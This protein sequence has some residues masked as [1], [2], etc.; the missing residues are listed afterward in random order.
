VA[1]IYSPDQKAKAFDKDANGTIFGEGGGIVILKTL[2][3]ALADGDNIHA[4]IKGSAVNSDGRRSNGMAAPSQEGQADVIIKAMEKAKIDPKGISYIEA[5]GTGTNIGDPI[6]I[7]AISNAYDKLGYEKGSVPV[8]SVKTN[9]GHLD[10]AAGI[11]AFIKTVLMLKHKEI[12]ASLHY[13]EPNPLI[14]FENSPVYVNDKLMEWKSDTVRRAGI[15]SLG[16]I[17]TNSHVIV[18]EAKETDNSQIVC[19]KN[20]ITLSARTESSLYGIAKR[21]ST[22][23]KEHQSLSIN[24]IAYTLNKGRRKYKNLIV[25][26]AESCDELIQELDEFIEKRNNTSSDELKCVNTEAAAVFIFPD[27]NSVDFQEIS[28]LINCNDA[29]K[30]LYDRYSGEIKECV[31][32][33]KELVDY[34]LYLYS[35][36]KLMEEYS[37][38]PKAVAGIGTGDAIAELV[39][40][41][42]GLHECIKR[43]ENES[44]CSKMGINADKLERLVEALIGSGI[45]TFTVFCPD[46]EV[47]RQLNFVLAE[48]KSIKKLILNQENHTFH[49][50]MEVLL[51]G[52]L[53][54]D[55]ENAYKY[56]KRKRISL[57][58]YVFDRK[59]YFIRAEKDVTLPSQSDSNKSLVSSDKNVREILRGI[60]S[61]VYSGDE[62]LEDE[63]NIYDIDFDSILAMQYIGKV[64]KIYDVNIPMRLFLEDKTI[65][66]IFSFIEEKINSGIEK[67]NTVCKDKETQKEYYPVSSP[68][69]RM[70]VLNRLDP[71]N[72][73]YNIPSALILEGMVDRER[74]EN[75]FKKLI[76][77]HD[78]LRTSFMLVEN[79]PVQKINQK[80]EFKVEYTE[81]DESD[82]DNVIKDFIRPFDLSIAPLFR[83]RLVRTG[84]NKHFFLFDIHHIIADATSM[85]II[86]KEFI[87]LYEGNRLDHLKLQYKDYAIWQGDQKKA[88]KIKGHE[89][90]WLKRLSG[91]I[92][93]LNLPLDYKRPAVQSFEGDRIYFDT[94]EELT[95]KLN[96][97]AKETG[98]TLFMVLMAAYNI[99]LYRYTGQEDIIV[100]TPIA[101]RHNSDFQK[102]IGFF[103]NTLPIR[104]FPCGDKTF[105]EFLNEVKENSLSAY[106]NQDYQ[107]E[108]MIERLGVKR[109]TSRSPIFDVLFTLQSIALSEAYSKDINTSGLK[110]TPYMLKNRTSKFD[111]TLNAVEYENSIR[112]EIEYCT[113]L[114]KKGTI[115]RF[116]SHFMNALR[117]IAANTEIK[118]SRVDILS[119]EEKEQILFGFNN[120]KS[121]YAREKA[122]YELFEEQAK[123][124]PDRIALVFGDK[125][126][127]YGELNEKADCIASTL[128]KK[129]VD[130]KGSIV[131]ILIN[132][133]LEMVA[134]ILGVLKSGAAY[135][136]IDPEYPAGRIKYMIEDS[137]TGLLITTS[138]LG[139]KT[140]FEGETL[141]LDKIDYHGENTPKVQAS[142]K[143]DD[144]AYMI[145]T[146][147]STGN[148]KGVMIEHASLSNFVAGMSEKI[149]FTPD[150]TMLGLTTV[151][152]DIFA[153]EIY[154]PL[155]K[156]MKIV[157]ANEN[158]QRDSKLL[159]ELILR[160]K[161]DMLQMTPSRMQL[162][163]SNEKSFESLADVKDIIIGGEAFPDALL[164]KLKSITTSK[165]YNVYGPTETTVWSAIKDL[166]GSETVNIGKPIANTQIFIVNKEDMLQPVNVTGELCIGGDGL[167]RGYWN[168]EELTSEKFVTN[169]YTK[170]QMYKTGDLAKWHSNGEISIL[171]RT[172]Q[173]VKIRGYRVEVEEIEKQILSFG[174]IKECVVSAKNDS[175]GNKYLV[176]YYVSG[177]EVNT[178][179]MRANLAVV[180]PEYMIPGMYIKLD[181]IPRTANGKVD[182]NALPE[183]E[184]NRP[185]LKNEYLEPS[186]DTEKKVYDIW[187]KLL[188]VEQIGSNDNFF[189]VGGNSLLLV[190]M[191]EELE[192]CYPEKVS[193]ADIF[194][195]PT[196]SKLAFLLDREC[197]KIRE[198]L[199]VETLQIPRRY[200][201]ADGEN[202]DGM[203][204]HFSLGCEMT[205]SLKMLADS[206]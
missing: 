82:I 83:V 131:G 152:F 96:S 67:E 6:E 1:T 149:E 33:Y 104:N 193:V 27:I 172:D 147:G 199:N 42:I 142:S 29:Y 28:N 178:S 134:G 157:I 121:E 3:K 181:F 30:G 91:E 192:R 174:N 32:M 26:T 185:V 53:N 160:N 138:K 102:I 12:P 9:T 124:T 95:G 101:G 153:L 136:P 113:K 16:M 139:Y 127:T 86:V 78:S 128:K 115:E 19:G 164:K 119:S 34:V 45:N 125:H 155:I 64:K 14:D 194:A 79:E 158:E 146:S 114:F 13:K 97:I 11:A 145:Y 21:I 31:S 206:I 126:W 52:G 73:V 122:V 88:G 38:K 154:L 188:S 190:Q 62:E 77:R 111:M 141:L 17:G 204:M 151:S 106:E 189:D 22:Y 202:A 99:L 44:K 184:T 169:P 70:Y 76:E 148:P 108:E 49:A 118:L 18:E 187:S 2:D 112:F 63:V 68:Q 24:D 7:S 54:V 98:T 55:W 133:S 162:L 66:E 161:V 71:S 37:L 107:F 56:S 84:E 39:M 117:E 92:P 75:V 200:L 144:L 80:T 59:S 175:Q 110:F 166:T 191:N 171:G 163:M 89:E 48:K 203:V 40:G 196:I 123:R 103:L 41:N 186:T 74:I 46:M 168:R 81:A 25:L 60:F 69:K 85:S 87:N 165:I 197:E 43:V 72:T 143:A 205:K 130:D 198:D 177:E 50:A 47:A 170:E 51:K 93:A 159:G 57:P 94:D 10:Y 58:G 61:E 140:E 137:G 201:A 173:Q 20:I 129:G 150:K 36:A 65:G 195:F 100:G 116:A 105:R 8:G 179:S 120:T 5:H 23:L 35:Y 90:Y 176:A 182:R 109:D 15:T 132:R 135:L 183:P 4:I 180:L 156:G 167:S